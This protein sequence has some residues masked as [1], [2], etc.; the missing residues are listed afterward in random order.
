M[1]QKR[2]EVSND[3]PLCKLTRHLHN[4]H[5]IY[6]VLELRSFTSIPIWQ[7][8]VSSVAKNNYFTAQISNGPNKTVLIHLHYGP[9]KFSALHIGSGV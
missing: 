2:C 9:I 8:P 7:A 6:G 5:L 4:N 3:L 1:L